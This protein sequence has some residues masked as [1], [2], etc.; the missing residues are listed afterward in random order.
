MFDNLIISLCK[1][2]SILSEEVCTFTIILFDAIFQGSVN[3][4]HMISTSNKLQRCAQTL[5]SLCRDHGNILR[6]GWNNILDCLINLFSAHLL[7]DSLA[8]VSTQPALE[9]LYHMMPCDNQPTPVIAA[10]RA[11]VCLEYHMMSCDTRTQSEQPNEFQV[12][13]I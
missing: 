4:A 7:P 11:S 3:L 6:E 5:F 1:L 13:T 8:V 9:A 10:T 12:H 2:S